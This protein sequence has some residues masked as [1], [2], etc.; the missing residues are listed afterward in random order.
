MIWED[1]GTGGRPGRLWTQGE[2]DDRLELDGDSI[3]LNT[4]VA[5]PGHNAPAPSL[6]K[7]HCLRRKQF[8]LKPD[9]I[10][11]AS[12]SHDVASEI[13]YEGWLN[14]KSGEWYGGWNRRYFVL[15]ETE[16]R[17]YDAETDTE[18][19]CVI[20]LHS[21][22]LDASAEAA[23]KIGRQHS[24]F[25][26]VNS[27]LISKRSQRGK[28]SA[29][30]KLYTLAAPDAAACNRWANALQAA[31]GRSQELNWLADSAETTA[32]E[33]AEAPSNWGSEPQPQPQPA[34]AWDPFSD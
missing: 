25:L 33:G 28:G 5:T 17:Y 29:A 26:R 18:P 32:G 7:L 31:I 10:A 4:L 23:T 20:N 8:F 2:A 16:L 22:S 21:F 15:Q 6:F 27:E 30:E 12:A 14:K 34:V 19:K 24:F 1:N 9:H 13:M 11:S 3:A